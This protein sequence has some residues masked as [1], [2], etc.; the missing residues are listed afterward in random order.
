MLLAIDTGNT[1]TV[2]ALYKGDELVHSWR[3]QTIASRSADEYASFLNELFA[4]AY[5][6]W[7]DVSDV[8][9][10]SVVPDVNFHI[11]E[12]CRK[13]LEREVLFVDHQ[14]AGVEIDMARPD[15]VGA[16]RLVNAAAVR[17][18]YKSPAIVIDFGTATTF[19]V[20]DGQ[21]RYAGGAISPGIN[22]SVSAL[23][24]AAAKLPSVTIKKPDTVIGKDTVGAIQSGIYW[25]YMGLIEGIISNI[26]KELGEQPFVI[27]TG[28]LAPLFAGNTDAIDEIDDQLIL[29]GLLVIH[30]NHKKG[31]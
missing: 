9:V 3:C 4:L 5:V 8:I 7:S 28:G 21:G 11:K 15:E 23:H 24:Q 1:N 22:L 17:A 12:F 14:V 6:K 30:Q 2:F 18:H 13:Y 10:S 25:G 16:D 31:A 26:T 19:D 20:I 27:A 29:K